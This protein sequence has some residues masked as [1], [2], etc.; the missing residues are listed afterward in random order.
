MAPNSP[1]E[2]AAQTEP[3]S[4]SKG[5]VYV[6]ATANASGAFNTS[7]QCVLGSA[8]NVT[9]SVDCTADWGEGASTSKQDPSSMV[10]TSA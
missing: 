7:N 8:V 5:K 4:A 10:A 9:G 1:S 3:S 2:C 6:S